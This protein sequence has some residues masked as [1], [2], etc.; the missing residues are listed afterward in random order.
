MNIPDDLKLLSFVYE[1]RGW[2]LLPL[3]AAGGIN[4]L[5]GR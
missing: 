4:L 2:V 1:N 5:P 3:I